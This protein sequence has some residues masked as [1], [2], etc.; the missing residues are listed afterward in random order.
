MGNRRKHAALAQMRVRSQLRGIEHRAGGHTRVL[1]LFHGFNLGVAPAPFRH[2][3]IDVGRILD[4]RGRRREARI[5]REVFTA[6][7]F[8]QPLPV[9]VAGTRRVNHH[10]IVFS[11]RLAQIQLAGRR[12]AD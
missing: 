1:Q 9:P 11:A 4:A 6:D 8:K 7:H 10:V 5:F 12:G 3:R 2:Q